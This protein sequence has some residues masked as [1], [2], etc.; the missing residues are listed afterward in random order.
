MLDSESGAHLCWLPMSAPAVSRDDAAP[1]REGEQLDGEALNEFLRGKLDLPEELSVAQFPHGHS[2]LTY[3]LRSGERE[4]VLRRGPLGPVAAKAH[5]MAREYRVL[6]ATHPHY[7]EAPEAHLLCENPTVIGAPFFIME[8]RHG[9]ILRDRVP[10]SITAFHDY[11]AV[12]SKAVAGGLVRLHAVNVNGP[13]LSSLG[14]PDGFVERQ[15]HGWAE[16]W[17]RAQTEDLPKMQSVIEWLAASIPTSQPAALVHND[18][19]LD[20]VM[21]SPESPAKIEAVLDWEMATIGDPLVDVGLTLCYWHWIAR[22]QPGSS[23]LPTLTSGKGWYTREEFLEQYVR[24]TGRDLSHIQFYEVLGLFKL[25]VI[26]QQIFYRF[27]RGQTS[28]ER[29]RHFDQRVKALAD[30]AVSLV[31]SAR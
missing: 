3:L 18:Y 9:T 6:R 5:D 14:K 17:H 8:R 27:H 19:K 23:V 7:P 11:P 24:E 31:E 16:R 13:E 12:I 1:I 15:V 10:K 4:Y 22:P 29:F 25:A 21:L 2:N 26:L 30:L 28:D 20:N